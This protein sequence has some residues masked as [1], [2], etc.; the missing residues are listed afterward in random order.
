M[1]ESS[2]A[3]RKLPPFQEQF[4]IRLIDR[5]R[6]HP[7]EEWDFAR[8]AKECNV[9][10]THFR[11]LFKEVAKLPP[12]QF[13]IQCRLQHAANQLIATRDSVAEI[14]ERVG[15]DNQFYFSRLFKEKYLTSPLEYRREFLGKNKE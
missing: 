3:S 5:I 9:T 6:R 13:L 15:I 1:H 10:Q 7:E 4:F 14:A 8:E 11:R 12:Q 2:L